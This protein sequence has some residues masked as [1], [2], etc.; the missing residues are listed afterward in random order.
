MISRK[1]ANT[2][3]VCYDEVFASLSRTSR[4]VIATKVFNDRLYDFLFDNDYAAWFCNRSKRLAGRRSVKEWIMKLHTGETLSAGFSKWTWQ[5]RQKL[6]Q[7]YLAN[8]AEDMLQLIDKGTYAYNDTIRELVTAMRRQLELD[9]YVYRDGSLLFSEEDVLDTQEEAGILE[10]LYRQLGLGDADTALHHL[11]LSEDHY[12]AGRWDDA[13]SNAR[14][15]FE[16]TLSQIAISH[17]RKSPND[18]PLSDEAAKQP[19]RVRDYLEQ[20]GLLETKE[21]EAIAKVYGLLS[22]TGGH[23]YMASNDQARLLRHLALTLSQFAM[24]RFQGFC[25]PSQV[26]RADHSS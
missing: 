1:G 25:A 21:K 2:I 5:Q 12:L 15:F 4:G 11:R 3:G 18:H 8:L 23:P 20:E 10:T 6:G 17:S 16:C 7:R 26:P 22:N 9:G 24:L 13:I 14:K 19:V